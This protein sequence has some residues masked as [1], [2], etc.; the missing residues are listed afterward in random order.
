MTKKLICV[1][2]VILAIAMSA[3]AVY[4]IGIEKEY[5]VTPGY[6]KNGIQYVNGIEETTRFFGHQI[7]PVICYDGEEATNFYTEVHSNGGIGV[8]IES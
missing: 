6:T 7:G 5:K 1:V 8:F 2:M 3:I 4:T